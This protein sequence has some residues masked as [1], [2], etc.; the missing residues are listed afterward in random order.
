LPRKASKKT[1]NA[2]LD[3]LVSIQVREANG[4]RCERCGQPATQVHH[5]YSRRFRRIRW[6]AANLVSICASCHRFAHD[7]PAA[8]VEW[9][10]AS[11]P[12]DYRALSDPEIRAPI[13]RSVADLEDLREQLREAA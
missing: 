7:C 3:R 13:N 12:E 11:R 2:T 5:F 8:F 10:K 9:F 4:H 1:L 6:S